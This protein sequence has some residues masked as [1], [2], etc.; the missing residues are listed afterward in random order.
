MT[1]V[2]LNGV[3]YCLTQSHL[4]CRSTHSAVDHV[5]IRVMPNTPCL[6]G[7]AASAY[8]LGNNATGEDAEKVFALISSCGECLV[9]C[10]FKQA[11]ALRLCKT[12]EFF[13]QLDHAGATGR[14]LPAFA[15][16]AARTW[17][18]A[19][20]GL[21]NMNTLMEL[22]GSQHACTLIAAQQQRASPGLA[23]I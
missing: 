9:L 4:S 10:D 7:Q 8:V 19:V 14:S 23:V 2:G 5:Q 18:N 6:I 1:N 17:L 3:K 15:D 12:S 13:H 20:M 22:R 11:H 21:S 16:S